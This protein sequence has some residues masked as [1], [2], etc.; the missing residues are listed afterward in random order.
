MFPFEKLY[1]VT[2]ISNENDTCM[3]VRYICV[4]DVPML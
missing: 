4:S 1:N 3:F 2:V